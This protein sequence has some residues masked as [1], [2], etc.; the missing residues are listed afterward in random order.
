MNCSDYGSYEKNMEDLPNSRAGLGHDAGARIEK[1][2]EMD[3][4]EL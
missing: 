1:R 3:A 2:A 4:F